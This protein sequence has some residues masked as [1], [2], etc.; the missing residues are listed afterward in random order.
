MVDVTREAYRL[1][2][3]VRLFMPWP[4]P[5]IVPWPD[6]CGHARSKAYDGERVFVVVR[7]YGCLLQLAAR[8]GQRSS[9]GADA[10][11]DVSPSPRMGT[12]DAVDNRVRLP[13]GPTQVENIYMWLK[14]Y[15]I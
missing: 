8:P 10:G 15:D 14:V 2:S 7:C 12:G 1:M 5:A 4:C 9:S 3:V 6:M 11:S 13:E